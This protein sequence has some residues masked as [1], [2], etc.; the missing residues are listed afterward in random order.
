MA[1]GPATLRRLLAR[2]IPRLRLLPICFGVMALLA[3]A[4][5]ERMWR[6][7]DAAMEVIGAAQ[8]ADPPPA[9]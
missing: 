8:A 4:K 1:R 7:G 3:V 9:A 2:R 5:L 6:M